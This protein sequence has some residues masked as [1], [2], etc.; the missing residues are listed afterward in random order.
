MTLKGKVT[1]GRVFSA[2]GFCAVVVALV[3]VFSAMADK[4]AIRIGG[5]VPAGIS[6]LGLQVIGQKEL[7]TGSDASLRVITTNHRAGAPLRDAEVAIYLASV[8]SGDTTTLLRSETNAYGTLAARFRM[9][10]VEPGQ[11]ELRVS[12]TSPIGEAKATQT[13]T[14]KRDYR[15]LLT[16]DKPIYQPNQMIHIRAL[17]LR[18]PKLSAAA[19]KDITLEVSD[20]KGNKVFKKALKTDDFGIAAADF[21]LADE[22]NMGRYTV[23]ALLEDTKAEKTLTVER[24]VL[25][26][27]KVTSTLK[28]DYYMPGETVEGTVQAD[29]FF[30]KPVADSQVT[31][32]LSTFDVELSEIATLKGATDANGTYEFE[33]T[34]STHF[35]GQPL[36]RGDAYLQIDVSVKDQA[37]H[38]EKVTRTA[39][40]A[41]DP[42]RITVAPE[43]GHIV[44]NVPN[45]FYIMTTYPDGTPAADCRVRIRGEQRAL[46]TDALG[47]AR[48]ETTP[49]EAPYVLEIT[50]TDKQG[51]T[52]SKTESMEFDPDTEG[53]LLRTDRSLYKVGDQVRCTTLSPAG[54]GTVFIDVVKDRQTMLTRA[55]EMRKGRGAASISLGP[56]M[57]GTIWLSAYRIKPDG[58]IVRD[59][60]ALYVDP[61]DD[62]RI[63]LKANKKTYKPGDEDVRINFTVTDERKR[64]VAAALGVHVVDESVFALQ[65]IQP[66]MEKVYFLLERELMEPKY[67]IHQFTPMEIVREPTPRP[68]PVAER[69]QEAAGFLFAS[70][71]LPD[72]QNFVINTFAAALAELKQKWAEAMVKDAQTIQSAIRRYQQK[73]RDFPTYEQGLDVLVAEKFLS[74]ADT[75]D[76]WGNT[77]KLERPP[78]NPEDD[79]IRQPFLTSVG[80]DGREGTL[81]DIFGVPPWPVQM[82]DDG[83]FDRDFMFAMPGGRMMRMRGRGLGGAIAMDALAVAE[84][85]M[86]LEEA[87]AGMPVAKSAAPENGDGKPAVRVRE[88]FPETMYTNP[89]VI[90]DKRGRASVTFTMADSITEWRLTALANSALGQL[91]STT[92]GLRCFQDFFIDID[93]PVA[94]TDGD[95]V[96]IPV[97]VY[98]YLPVSQKLRLE[99]TKADWFTLS[100]SATETMQIDSNDV[101][102]AYFTIT[103]KEIG[104]QRL[105]VHGYGDKMSDAITRQIRIEPNGQLR[106]LA[107][108]GRLKGDV[109]HTVTIPRDAVANASNILVKVY[110]GI[111]SQVVEGLDAILQM[112]FG[113][114]EQTSS[115]TY[116]NVLA[117]DYMKTTQQITPEIRMKA[118]GYVN[119]GYQRLVSF[120]V[121]GG[122]FSWFGNAPANKV[123]T[124]YGVM[125]FADMARVHE[126]DPAVISRTQQWLLSQQEDDGSW[127]PDK[128]FL[129]AESWTRIQNSSLLPTA[130]V[131][132]ALVDS[133]MKAGGAARGAEYIRKHLADAKDAYTLAL[134]CNAL[135]SAAPDD[136]S[137]L[138]ALDR[139][140][141][142]AKEEDDKLWWES[143]VETITHAH[144]N[145]ASLETT[146]VAGYA[147]IRSGRHAGEA[148]KVLN[149]LIASKA[150]N[151]TWGSTQATVMA[152]KDMV[153]ALGSAT[154]KVNAE[155][156]VMIDGQRAAGLAL[157]SENS[158]VLQQVDLRKYVRPGDNN[159]KIQF[160]G[161]GSSLYSIVTKYYVPWEKPILRP[162]KFMSIDVKYDKTQLAKD[163]TVTCSVEVQQNRPGTSG[164]VVVDLGI[165]PGFA[166]EA[167]DL[168]ELVGSDVIQ[169]FNLTGRQ[170]IVYL[171]T[172][173]SGKAVRFSYRLRAKFPIRAQTPRSMAYEY[174]D[175]D[176]KAFAKP[177]EMQV[178]A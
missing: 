53:L 98:N 147:L 139:L 74:V 29:Y 132:W 152:L 57:A 112:P 67:E 166:V 46:R 66:G 63:E 40:V 109:E 94:L 113:C 50:A 107:I 114:F 136:D 89:R 81:D 5:A 60:N 44:P 144:G 157:T 146:A 86:E 111:F 145:T 163:D 9:P 126:V 137:T 64:P 16:T 122:G 35:V 125:L 100:G 102:V 170:I 32:K 23:R 153:A 131:T 1:V 129:H 73:H 61:A 103:A 79:R 34:L 37:D 159:I 168:A 140:L 117:L 115:A 161:E 88:Y 96:S 172:L 4:P 7:L 31:V 178:E 13:I 127:T 42:I 58:D 95:Q 19:A 18:R 21:Q 97:A 150:P 120:E 155:V 59:T 93:L 3:S 8:E 65:E 162:G 156:A 138:E 70:A 48:Y 68:I 82:M 123:L 171:E 56:E 20:G 133:G 176:N 15:V 119:T 169:K 104:N 25:P 99:L 106:E 28:K 141:K 80:P 72:D 22:I 167:G 54:R 165:P 38:I 143:D 151:G 26:K 118:E 78:W 83:R 148:T 27:F 91:G 108:N 174:Y 75:R 110:P 71:E 142:M 134:V 85:A 36:E 130:Y 154:Q 55:L 12:A 92:A 41:K 84:G 39:H 87:P 17:A 43:T 158:D 175:P 52:A 2:L 24:Y 62:L 135:V 90:T 164:M 77:Y 11:Y 105:T 6:P 51:N 149:Y 47:I 160:D 10:D 45:Q 101:D 128:S 124:A 76:Q 30:G 49:K 69:R 121:P 116:P 177:V 14:L 33:G 173:E